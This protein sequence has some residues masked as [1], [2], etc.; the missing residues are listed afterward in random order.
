MSE[1]FDFET[2]LSISQTKFGIYLF[3]TKNRNNLYVK[4][5]NFEITNFINYSNLKKFLDENVFRIEK[6][7]GKFVKNIFII[8]DHENILNIQIGIKQKNY[9][10]SKSKIYLQS[11]ITNAKD[12][13]KENY[14]NEKI[15]HIIIKNYLIDGKK[16]SYL[17]DNLEYEQLNLEIQFKSISNEIIY[18]LNKVLQNYQINITKYVDGNYI[19][20]FFNNDIEISKMTFDILNGCN[21]NEVM[22]VQKNTK[23]LGFFEK[24]FNLFD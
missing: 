3:D 9:Q 2:Y 8:I 11:S 4:E 24:F 18:N 10:P 22:V 12:L 6:L 15:M 23:K 7:L 20:S 21:E 19:K 1:I 13:F 17:K 16:Y 14:P 5:I